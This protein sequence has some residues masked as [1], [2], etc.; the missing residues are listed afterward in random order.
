MVTPKCKLDPSSPRHHKQTCFWVG[1]CP[2][3]SLAQPA[4]PSNV[5]TVQTLGQWGQRMNLTHLARTTSTTNII[6]I[7]QPL[8]DNIGKVQQQHW[9]GDA[10]ACNHEFDHWPSANWDWKMALLM[11]KGIWGFSGPGRYMCMNINA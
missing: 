6:Q 4:W 11:P 9:P 8:I 5:G 7:M 2:H 10:F 3:Q 1:H